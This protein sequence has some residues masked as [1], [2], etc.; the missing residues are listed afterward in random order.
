MNRRAL[1]RG[2]VLG[3]IGTPLAAGAQSAGKVS[4]I[5][6]LLALYSPHADP[7]QAFRRRLR[8]FGCI[9]G[10]SIV[11]EWRDAQQNS[12][13]L[14]RLAAEPVRLKVDLIVADVTSATR[15]AMQAAPTVPIVM[16]LPADPS[17]TGSCPA[18]RAQ[19]G[20]SRELRSCIQKSARNACNC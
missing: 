8:E 18:S 3:V 10:Q 9:E 13:Q 6:V 11:I 12:D 5:G 2:L 7:P 19:V 15:A 14:S 1:L 17:A 20:T 16:A 4:R